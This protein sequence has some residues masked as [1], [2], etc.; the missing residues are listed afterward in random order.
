MLDGSDQQSHTLLKK[1]QLA[2]AILELK[3]GFFVSSINLL[4]DGKDCRQFPA[5]IRMTPRIK[6]VGHGNC[7]I[8]HSQ[9]RSD[10]LKRVATSSFVAQKT[11]SVCE[12]IHACSN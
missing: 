10:T 4:D 7:Q 11:P 9:I 12:K 8:K 2:A 5:R 6:K 1:L 3:L